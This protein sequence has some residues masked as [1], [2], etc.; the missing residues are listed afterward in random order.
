MTLLPGARNC[1]RG[2]MYAF[3]SAAGCAGV[4]VPSPSLEAGLG[5]LTYA[6]AAFMILGGLLGSVGSVTDRWLGELLSAPLLASALL[7]YGFA[8]WA[9]GPSNAVRVA[10]GALM[11]AMAFGLAARWRD[12]YALSQIGRSP[13]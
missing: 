13:N 1:L 6:W 12:V 8:L 2:L 7:V 4:F 5:I 9:T 3:F 10:I 11:L